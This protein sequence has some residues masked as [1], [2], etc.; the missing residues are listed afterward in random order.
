MWEVVVVVIIVAIVLACTVR[1]FYR[2][3]S[4]K[5][6]RCS[7]GCPASGRRPCESEPA[8]RETPCAAERHSDR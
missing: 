3:V 5:R 2:D 7:C 8:S 1:A 4:G 6:G